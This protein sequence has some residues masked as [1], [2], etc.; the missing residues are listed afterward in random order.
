MPVVSQCG[1]RIGRIRKAGL[2]WC[3]AA[4]REAGRKPETIARDIQILR[5]VAN[6]SIATAAQRLVTS[7]KSVTNV[8]ERYEKIA[9]GILEGNAGK[10][11]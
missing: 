10:G 9:N 8:L 5:A 2:R 6:G 7:T 1:V 3:I 4:A 11:E